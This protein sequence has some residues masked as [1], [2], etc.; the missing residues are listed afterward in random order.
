MFFNAHEHFSFIFQVLNEVEDT[1]YSLEH[2]L[3]HVQKK[4]NLKVCK[5]LYRYSID[6]MNTVLANVRARIAGEEPESAGPPV[7]KKA[8]K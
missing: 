3:G 2:A 6:E 5:L 1:V 4:R 8:G 7:K